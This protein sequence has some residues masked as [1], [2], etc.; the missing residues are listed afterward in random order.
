MR[1]ALA[2]DEPL[3]ADAR[4]SL[5]ADAGAEYEDAAAITGLLEALGACG[6]EPLRLPFGEDFAT[7]AA[8]L[9]P[10]LVFNI[11]EGLSGPTRESIVPAWLDHLGIGY[12]GSDGLTLAVALDKAWT[13][14]IATGVGVRTPAFQRVARLAD[15]AELTLT[16]PLF[17]KPNGEGSS[18][19]IRADSK[20]DTRDA[21]ARKVAWT[22]ATYRQDCLIE[23]FAPGREFC[24]GILGNAE[25]HLLPVAEVMA[26]GGVHTY[27]SKHQHRKEVV[28]PAD[29]PA[30]TT[31]ELRQAGLTVY[32]ALRCRDLARVDFRMDAA[33]RAAF[34]EINP[35]PG[36]ASAYSIFPVQAAA[37]GIGYHE[38]IGTI[39]DHALRRLATE[40]EVCA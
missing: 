39:V 8:A 12:T 5:P 20:I 24:V 35:L 21:L 23:E 26:P 14:Q 18:M 6:H 13:K 28:C 31:D 15:L 36:L 34:I 25:P 17:V 37:D 11:A 2:Y 1:V 32:R 19:G 30:S 29:I 4:A 22:L 40:Q 7:R 27:E 10:A 38:L 33:G 9:A 16:P 3:A